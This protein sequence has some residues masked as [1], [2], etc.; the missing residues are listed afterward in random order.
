MRILF[1]VSSRTD[2]AYLS[3]GIARY[4]SRIEHY[5][6]FEMLATP[7]PGKGKNLQ[8]EALRQKEGEALTKHLKDGDYIVL[9]DER[10]SEYTSEQFAR[11]L[12]AKMQQTA[13]R[14]VFIVGGPYG[15]SPQIYAMA[16][17]K[18]SLSRMTFSH[19]MIRLLFVEQLYRALTIINHQPYHHG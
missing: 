6:S 11:Y 1:L 16:H 10:G 4:C 8:P 2:S 5:V 12:E 19:Q 15:F 18:M 7:D 9:L 13:K 3:E 14:L 17:E